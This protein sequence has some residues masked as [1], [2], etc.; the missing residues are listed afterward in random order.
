MTGVFLGPIIRFHTMINIEGIRKP[1]TSNTGGIDIDG[2]KNGCGQNRQQPYVEL[3]P[4]FG[5]QLPRC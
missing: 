4:P 3:L 5:L 1:S 2:K